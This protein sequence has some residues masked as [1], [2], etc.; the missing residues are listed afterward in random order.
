MR[1]LRSARGRVRGG[2]INAGSVEDGCV[3]LTHRAV[4]LARAL[5]VGQGRPPAGRSGLVVRG[6]SC[7]SPVDQQHLAA[8]LVLI[9]GAFPRIDH[10]ACK[11]DKGTQKQGNQASGYFNRTPEMKTMPRAYDR[12]EQI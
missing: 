11:G 6:A 4:P 10:P 5:P 1:G 7:G 12:A 2:I 9:Q 3:C 8:G